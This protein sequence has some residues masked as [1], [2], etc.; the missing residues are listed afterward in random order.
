MTL[1]NNFGNHSIQ[2]MSS[3]H[4]TLRKSLSLRDG[5]CVFT[6]AFKKR[7]REKQCKV[8]LGGY[9]WENVCEVQSKAFNMTAEIHS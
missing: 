4:E 6:H 1:S 3:K 8:S 7:N 2:Y 5:V 9:M